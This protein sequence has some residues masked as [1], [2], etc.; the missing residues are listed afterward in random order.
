MFSLCHHAGFSVEACTVKLARLMNI[1]GMHRETA[2]LW[3]SIFFLQKPNQDSDQFSKLGSS[4][5]KISCLEGKIIVTY[6]DGNICTKHIETRVGSFLFVTNN[7]LVNGTESYK[8][9]DLTSCYL[10]QFWAK[11]VRSECSRTV[12]LMR[13]NTVLPC[14]PIS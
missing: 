1:E 11:T 10:I 3:M 5:F 14:S 13:Y 2:V 7:M 8:I 6:L 4:K 12:Y 9:I